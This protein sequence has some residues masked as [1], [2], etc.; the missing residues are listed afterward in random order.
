VNRIGVDGRGYEYSGDSLIAG[1]N[2]EQ[3]TEVNTGLDTMIT[4]TLKAS[5]LIKLRKKLGVGNDWD[6]FELV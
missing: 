5:E 3:L 2:A 4:S 6:G 1:P